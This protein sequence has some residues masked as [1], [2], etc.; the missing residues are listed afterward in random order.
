LCECTMKTCS[1]HDKNHSAAQWHTL[2]ELI[3]M[4]STLLQK[5]KS[6]PI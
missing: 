3:Y 4:S 1:H 2:S 5:P 6:T